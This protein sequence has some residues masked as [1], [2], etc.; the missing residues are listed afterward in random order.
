MAKRTAGPPFPDSPGDWIACF[1]NR[2]QVCG[3]G[4]SPEE[5]GKLIGRSGAT[6]RR[7]EQNRQMPEE[8][9]IARMA[10]VCDL[11]PMQ[12]AFLSAACTRMRAMPA[13]NRRAFHE[14]ME[15][16]LSC[17]P[18]PAMILDGLFY[19]R[20]WNSYMDALASG[21]SRAFRQDIHP[22]ALMMRSGP[23]RLLGP[24]DKESNL[25]QG[26]RIFWMTTAVHCHRPEYAN[27]L[28][29]LDREPRF[30]QLWMNLALGKD[31]PNSPISFAR[32]LVSDGPHFEVY[33]RTI[34]FPPTYYLNE[35]QPA[36]EGSRERLRLIAEQGP[37]QVHFRRN[38]HWVNSDCAC[39]CQ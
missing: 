9:D 26:L 16:T 30:R 33:S 24:G 7:W 35:Y 22:M 11:S 1:R 8:K 20:A 25:Q 29:D 18:Y 34:T 38:L 12:I 10:E 17:T 21:T 39:G 4:P 13:P 19:I 27:M 6:V 3:R 36:D 31:A 32:A 23:N 28:A 15:R 37:P 14:Y 2:A 5:F